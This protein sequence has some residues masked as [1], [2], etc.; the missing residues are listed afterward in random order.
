MARRPVSVTSR[1][2]IAG[3]PESVARSLPAARDR[4]QCLLLLALRIRRGSVPAS[5]PLMTH[6]TFSGFPEGI[7]HRIPEGIRF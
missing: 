5:D 6:G 1:S 4:A 7:A 3:Y 2:A